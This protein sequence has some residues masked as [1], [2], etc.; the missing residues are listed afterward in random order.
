[1][2]QFLTAADGGFFASQDSDLVP[3]RKASD[4]FS[5]D[6]AGRRA[7]GIPRIDTNVYAREAGFLIE[8]LVT[9]H[10]FTRDPESL[11]AARRAAD[12]ISAERS[13]EGGG[14]RH[15]AKDLAGPYLGDTLAMGR[16]FLALYKAT[17]ERNWLSR[18]MAAA[19]FIDARFRYSKGG[20]AS[21]VADDA[22]IR[23]VPQIDENISL[24]RFANLLA[25]ISGNSQYR[26]MAQW[27]MRYLATPKVATRRTT[28]AGILLA[29]RELNRD[30]LHLTV[31][32]PKGEALAR[33]LFRAAL[34]QPHWY[35]RAEW[36]DPAEGPLPNPEVSY[37][38]LKLS[39]RLIH[40][41]IRK[42][43]HGIYLWIDLLD[44]T[45]V[46]SD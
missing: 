20:F 28:E 29:D 4:Y 23:P 30:P 36:W 9:Q 35:K 13:L 41:I 24:V 17:A 31:I 26:D 7:L 15:A 6:D 38:Q 8:A 39:L 46:H 34:D 40:C 12:Y 42:C 11:A 1:M 37:P 33:E 18:A 45:Q 25:Q 3:G 2:A 19:Q 44:S 5:L 10:E 16:A 27:A 21:A 32:G 22:V 14:F 43:N